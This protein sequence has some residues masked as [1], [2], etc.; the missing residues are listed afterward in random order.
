MTAWNRSVASLYSRLIISAVVVAINEYS[1]PIATVTN[2]ALARYKIARNSK[3]RGG[4]AVKST[5]KTA[6]HEQQPTIGRLHGEAS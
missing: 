5:S 6:N 2:D 1:D 3:V 4:S